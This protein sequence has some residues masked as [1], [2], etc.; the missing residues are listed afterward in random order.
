[1][2]LVKFN[3]PS[4]WNVT[5]TEGLNHLRD[6][7]NRL[8]DLP[9]AGLENGSEALNPW[10]PPVDLHEDKDNLIVTTEIPG[11][12]KEDIEVSFHENTLT[13]SGERKQE[14]STKENG[15]SRQERYYGRF[16]RSVSL[17]KSVDP[18]KIKAAYKDGILTVTL[19][20][21][22]EAKPKQINVSVG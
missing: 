16:Q 6:E 22:E 10:A 4:L 19:P 3:R 20:K 15:V 12:T 21:T 5:A 8:F 2:R 7:V 11:V 17:P 18:S 1:M 14:K 9:F 13:V